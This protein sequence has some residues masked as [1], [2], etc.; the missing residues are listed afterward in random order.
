MKEKP[1]FIAF[2]VPE[3]STVATSVSSDVNVY[4][5]SISDSFKILIFLVEPTLNI[6]SYFSISAASND[7]FQCAK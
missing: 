2:T 6:N 1:R 4:S 7:F 5:S 3:L